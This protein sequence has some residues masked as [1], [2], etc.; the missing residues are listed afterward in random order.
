[1]SGE[2]V[3]QG[4]LQL[5]HHSVRNQS[6]G[7]T[8]PSVTSCRVYAQTLGSALPLTVLACAEFR[9]TPFKTVGS[10][11]IR[12]LIS[13]AFSTSLLMSIILKDGGPGN[14]SASV[15]EITPGKGAERL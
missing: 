4:A 3:Q 9:S 8:D 13:L 14:R 5:G 15:G 2:K 1:M 12:F 7:A 10:N 6:D 11:L